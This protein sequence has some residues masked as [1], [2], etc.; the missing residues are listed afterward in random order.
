MSY[1]DKFLDVKT[2]IGKTP[3][4]I[5]GAE[6]DSED[7]YFLCD[8]GKNILMPFCFDGELWACGIDLTSEPAP[9]FMKK[10]FIIPVKTDKELEKPQG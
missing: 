8:D 6:K 3:V 4:S 9:E 1:F 7:I 2:L 10:E 5:E